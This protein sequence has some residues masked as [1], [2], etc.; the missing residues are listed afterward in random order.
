MAPSARSRR[1]A[2]SAARWRGSRMRACAV[3]DGCHSR[4]MQAMSA[5]AASVRGR[6][7]RTKPAPM[8]WAAGA[9]P[10][11][12]AGERRP[13]LPAVASVGAYDDEVRGARVRLGQD[14]R[15]PVVLLP[16][17]PVAGRPASISRAVTASWTSAAR[18]RAAPMPASGRS[19]S[20][21]EVRCPRAV[22]HAEGRCATDNTLTWCASNIGQVRH[23]VFRGDI[24]GLVPSVSEPRSTGKGSYPAP[25]AP[26]RVPIG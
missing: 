1:A 16:G 4:T 15:R 6:V 10:A 8:P 20:A 7:G 22:R 26:G 3:V 23:Q 12:D 18:C 21:A 9:P 19:G 13:E 5:A 14:D 25:R 2:S 17:G 24:A 11:R